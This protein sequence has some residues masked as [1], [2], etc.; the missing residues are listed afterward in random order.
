TVTGLETS[1]LYHY[2]VAA[3]NSAG[4]SYGE[5]KTFTTGYPA[6]WLVNGK[7]ASLAPVKVEGTLTVKDTGL[8]VAAE[9]AV[10][11]I[12][13][14]LGAGGSIEKVT[15]AKGET[16]VTCRPIQTGWCGTAAIEVN[17]AYLS[18][19]TELVEVPIENGKG[20][21]HYEARL[22]YY[23]T[24]Q[25]GWTIKCAF[26]GSIATDNCLGESSGNVKNVTAGVTVG[27]DSKS[28][29]LACIGS[30]IGTGSVEGTLTLKST[31]EGKTFSV[32]G[33]PGP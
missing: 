15:G 5:D 30:A 3:S 23:G 16:T 17:A 6:K 18:W 28:P 33:A 10:T 1:T 7:E 27:L 25:S 14:V 22:R 32:Y 19:S 29:A 24:S 13:V 21:I 9:C 2:R 20:E 12:G 31:E 4:T 11:E 26:M 8:E